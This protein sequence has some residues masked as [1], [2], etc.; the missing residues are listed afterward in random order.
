[1][2]TYCCNQCKAFETSDGL[3]PGWKLSKFKDCHAPTYLCPNPR[4]K[5]FEDALRAEQDA[6]WANPAASAHH[7]SF[8]AWKAGLLPLA[9]AYGWARGL[10]DLDTEEYRQYFDDDFTP[11]DTVSEELQAA[12]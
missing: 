5:A 9:R 12:C 6:A 7:T 3:P 11:A 1:M 2:E 10:T 4:C 8:E